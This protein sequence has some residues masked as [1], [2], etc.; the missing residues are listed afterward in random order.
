[1]NFFNPRYISIFMSFCNHIPSTENF[2]GDLKIV[3]RAD[4][5]N[6]DKYRKNPRDN[7]E[8]LGN[9]PDACIV[10]WTKYRWL[11]NPIVRRGYSVRSKSTFAALRSFLGFKKSL[12]SSRYPSKCHHFFNSDTIIVQFCMYLCHKG[13]QVS[14]QRHTVNYNRLVSVYKLV[15]K[16]VGLV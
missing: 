14:W 1:M 7:W 12:L 6:N 13:C 8:N 2:E 5:R 9:P 11:T 4:L 15:L 10:P 16:H 3:L